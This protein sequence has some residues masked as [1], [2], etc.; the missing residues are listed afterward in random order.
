A[1]A[2]APRREEENEVRAVRGEGEVRVAHAFDSVERR[3][4]NARALVN[5][6]P[7]AHRV[8]KR[9]NGR[10]MAGALPTPEPSRGRTWTETV[11]PRADDHRTEATNDLENI[12]SV[13][14]SP[15]VTSSPVWA[16]RGGGRNVVSNSHDSIRSM[17]FNP[18]GTSSPVGARGLRIPVHNQSTG[19]QVQQECIPRKGM[20]PDST[21]ALSLPGDGPSLVREPLPLV[22]SAY[23]SFGTLAEAHLPPRPQA[24][25]PDTTL[26]SPFEESEDG[27]SE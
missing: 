18:V 24:P 1:I 26:D 20:S 9:V 4:I 15:L 21:V 8:L 10:M 12:R 19:Y 3:K 5:I 25:E 17:S 16:T 14:F 27:R 13:S 23:V 11:E 22:T 2:S 6:S 7:L